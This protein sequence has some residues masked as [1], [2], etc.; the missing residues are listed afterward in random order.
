MKTHIVN[1]L[2]VKGLDEEIKYVQAHLYVHKAGITSWSLEIDEPE[3]M[4]KFARVRRD[5]EKLDIT[6]SISYMNEL[7]GK[8]MV[9]DII[10]S[11]VTL[12]GS[13]RLVGYED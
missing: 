10:N 13:G 6:F 7:K 1:S 4:E 5:K 3:Q 2:S 12:N 9:K 8:V 11:S